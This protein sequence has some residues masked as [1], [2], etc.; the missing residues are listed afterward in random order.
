MTPPE[1]DEEAPRTVTGYRDGVPFSLDVLE[2]EHGFHLAKNVALQARSAL[3]AAREHGLTVSI[4]SAFR[5]MEEQRELYLAWQERRPGANPADKPG[6]SKHQ[7]GNAL[8][9]AFGKD[10]AHRNQEREEFAAIATAWGFSRPFS[11]EPWHFL[12]VA[13]PP[14][15]NGDIA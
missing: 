15:N 6:H 7:I 13:V 4:K 1:P 11:S 9:L 10:L 12:V 8:D 3:A 14:P 2:V 5:T